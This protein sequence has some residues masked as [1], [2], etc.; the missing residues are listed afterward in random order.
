[1]KFLTILVVLLGITFGFDLSLSAAKRGRPTVTPA[2]SPA[3]SEEDIKVGQAVGAMDVVLG[4]E[5]DAEEDDEKEE[6]PAGS[7][8][9]RPMLMVVSS[10]GFSDEDGLFDGLLDDFDHLAVKSGNHDPL[11]ISGDPF[12]P[13]YNKQGFIRLQASLQ[14]CPFYK[15]EHYALW[16]ALV[17]VIRPDGFAFNRIFF[18]TDAQRWRAEGDVKTLLARHDIVL[19]DVQK[20]LTQE[21]IIQSRQRFHAGI[22]QAIIMSGIVI[23]DMHRNHC[24]CIGIKRQEEALVLDV[25][26]SM[27]PLAVC[28]AQELAYYPMLEVLY[29]MYAERC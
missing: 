23:D 6:E 3:A 22:P 16:N 13:E 15:A 24:V 4:D 11:V 21:Q 1:M 26:D 25:Y 2:V 9:T 20:D 8:K 7:K 17:Q 10:G 29:R 12:S 27:H 19:I 5:E 14:Q 18:E 28:D